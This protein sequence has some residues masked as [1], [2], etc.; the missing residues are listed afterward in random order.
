VEPSSGDPASAS[1]RARATAEVV[2]DTVPPIMRVVRDHMRAGRAE[3]VSV[4]QFRAL[5][6]VRRNPGTDLSSVAEHMGASMPAVSELV[7]RLVRDGLVAR[8][9]DP[10]SRRR[11]RLT[12]SPDGERQLGEARER[13]LEWLA[14]RVASAAPEQLERIEAAL[15]DLRSALEDTVG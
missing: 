5:L 3:G 14:G 1:L 6:Y 11:V 2:L 4:P 10:R 15:R 13:T 12:L 7:S 8:E 9:L